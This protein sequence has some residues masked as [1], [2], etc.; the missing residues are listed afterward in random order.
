VASVLLQLSVLEPFMAMLLG[1]AESVTVGEVIAPTEIIAVSLASPSSPVQVSTKV[2]SAVSEPMISEPV[3][4]LAPDQS[5]EAIQL[6][7]LLVDQSNRML[8]L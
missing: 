5:P 2:L 7:T 3:V 6:P 1:I 8:P 4:P